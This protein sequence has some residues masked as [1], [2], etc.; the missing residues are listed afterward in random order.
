MGARLAG[1]EGAMD[2]KEASR[3]PRKNSQN[4]GQLGLLESGL[5]GPL[6]ILEVSMFG[7]VVSAPGWTREQEQAATR[8]VIQHY[9][10][11]GTPKNPKK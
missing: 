1:W 6:K 11:D 3:I 9:H 2:E 4:F 7:H 5:K 8:W 10:P